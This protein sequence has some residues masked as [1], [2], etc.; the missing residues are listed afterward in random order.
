MKETNFLNL[1]RSS[2][3]KKAKLKQAQ[4]AFAKKA[5]GVGSC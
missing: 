1:I 4:T 2:E 5:C 3:Q